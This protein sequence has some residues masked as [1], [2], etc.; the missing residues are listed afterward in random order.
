MKTS[1]PG[2]ARSSALAPMSKRL[3][4]FLLPLLCVGAS[5]AAENLKSRY[6]LVSA[7]PSVESNYSIYLDGR[8]L[9]EAKAEDIRLYRITPH[10][11]SEH[12]VVEAWS[13]GLHCQYRYFIL[14]IEKDMSVRQSP[15]FGQCQRLQSAT[16]RRNGAQVV[17][18]SDGPSPKT[19]SFAWQGG[20]L[21]KQPRN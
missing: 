6:G 12:I 5:H 3:V 18:S 21:S 1:R 15:S 14:T 13:P 20:R 11:A 2:A 16:Y 9:A 10:G 4:L 8:R 19:E 7:Q 17:L